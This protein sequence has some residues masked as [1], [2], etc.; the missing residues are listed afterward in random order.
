[1]PEQTQEL[2]RRLADGVAAEQASLDE[3]RRRLDDALAALDQL[4]EAVRHLKGF[5]ANGT[6]DALARLRRRIETLRGLNADDRA[7]RIRDLAETSTHLQHEVSRTARLATLGELAA[8]VAHEIRNPLCGM[9]LS[10]EVLL[11]KMDPG[12]SRRRLLANVQREVEKMKKVVENLLH[13]ARD[14]RPR[15]AEGHLEEAVA[16]TLESVR[17]HLQ[18]HGITPR[19]HAP[20]QPCRAAFDAELMQNVFRNIVLNALDAAEPGT[21]LDITFAHDPGETVSVSFADAGPGMDAETA[22]RVF[23][24]FFTTKA[25]GIGLGLA[26]SRKIVEAHGGR[27]ALDTA[28]GRGATFTVTLPCRF[29][30][31]AE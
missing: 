5:H 16:A 7:R 26:V 29:R 17:R 6:P 31:A 9:A 19:L 22:A 15:P 18:K 1:M 14:Y 24:P 12:D 8:S 27:I 23:E 20:E 25:K 11:T 21:P 28:P 30:G 10:V 13:F 2:T 4:Y 3:D